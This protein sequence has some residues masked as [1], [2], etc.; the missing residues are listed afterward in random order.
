[1]PKPRGKRETRAHMLPTST[2]V[3]GA[4]KLRDNQKHITIGRRRFVVE[5]WGHVKTKTSKAQFSNALLRRDKAGAPTGGFVAMSSWG[6]LD[7]KIKGLTS[8]NAWRISASVQ[9]KALKRTY[10]KA[11]VRWFFGN[12][13]AQA[14]AKGKKHLV[15][16]SSLRG[17]EPKLLR[18]MGFVQAGKTGYFVKTL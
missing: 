13:E 5:N 17:L 3:R 2:R 16:L 18:S 12:I 1:M 15:A 9:N 6:P 11:V 10:G 4:S 8:S 7:A 14:K